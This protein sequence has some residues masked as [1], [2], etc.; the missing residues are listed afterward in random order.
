MAK[1]KKERV[2]PVTPVRLVLDTCVWLDLAGNDTNEPLLGALETLY[3]QRVVDIV[4]PQIVRDEFENN[5]TGSSGKAAGASPES[6]NAT[7]WRSGR[8][9]TN[10]SGAAPEPTR[11]YSI[12]PQTHCANDAMRAT[13]SG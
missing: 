8:T 9:A 12:A 5:K 6:S 1:K 13:V 11:R 4:V 2:D 10:G 3:R 7:A